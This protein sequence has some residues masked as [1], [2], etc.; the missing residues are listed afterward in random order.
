MTGIIRRPNKRDLF[1]VGTAAALAFA[2]QAMAVEGTG[3]DASVE[4]LRKENARLHNQLAEMQKKLDRMKGERKS[5]KNPIAVKE[6]DSGYANGGGEDVGEYD[7]RRQYEDVRRDDLWRQHEHEWRHQA[8]GRLRQDVGRND[9]WRQHAVQNAGRVSVPLQPRF[10]RHRQYVPRP[11]RRDVDV[12]YESDAHGDGR[13][14]SWHDAD[15]GISGWAGGFPGVAI[16]QCQIS[17]H[18]DPDQNE[19][20]HG[21]VHDDVRRHRP[22]DCNGHDELQGNE[23]EHVHGYGQ[24]AVQLGY[25]FG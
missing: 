2:P 19:H 7:L 10:R 18:D 1:V 24:S 21:H 8:P 11:S 9:L 22:A 17:L 4:T 25:G 16:P 13:A 3:G 5:R 6:L 23:Y 12:Q 14:A 20:G 15:C